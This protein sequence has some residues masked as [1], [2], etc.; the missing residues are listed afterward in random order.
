MDFESML[1]IEEAFPLCR[2]H[3]KELF[4]EVAQHILIMSEVSKKVK[5]PI[6]ELVEFFY[7][8]K[9]KMDLIRE[10]EE[11]LKQYEQGD[12]LLREVSQNDG[13]K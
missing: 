4:D 13:F 9:L 8:G 12:K 1:E 5:V 3:N 2:T 6:E 7:R 11:V 10:Q